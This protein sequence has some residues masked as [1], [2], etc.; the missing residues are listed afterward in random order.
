MESNKLF[1]D[2]Q[3]AVLNLNKE[4][5]NDEKLTLYKYYKQANFGDNNKDKPSLFNLKETKKWEAWESVK[6]MS[7]ENAKIKYIKY[8]AQIISKYG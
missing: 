6:G 3:K 2:A 1:L 5:G 4:P 8:V 7:K